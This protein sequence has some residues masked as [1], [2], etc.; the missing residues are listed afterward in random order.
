MLLYF[1]KKVKQL[2]QILYA[3][4]GDGCVWSWTLPNSKICVLPNIVVLIWRH[5]KCAQFYMAPGTC[6]HFLAKQQ[7][8]LASSPGLKTGCHG[9][10]FIPCCQA[11][12]GMRYGH[13]YLDHG[14][15]PCP[16]AL[17]HDILTLLLPRW[18]GQY[19]PEMWGSWNGVNFDQWETIYGKELTVSSLPSS[20]TLYKGLF[21]VGDVSL[22]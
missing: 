3:E 11:P 21:R 17:R 15:V 2:T 14:R 4:S 9:R 13:W 18:T 5:V 1:I 22:L 6:S 8:Q 12:L 16:A 20:F 7:W 19:N 10:P